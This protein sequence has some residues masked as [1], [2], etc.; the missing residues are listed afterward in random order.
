MS[1]TSRSHGDS[2]PVV[3]VDIDQTGRTPTGVPVNIEG[4]KLDFFAIHL[5]NGSSTSNPA[6]QMG[7]GGA[8][9]T[10]IKLIQQKT[11]V[12]LFQVED[13]TSSNFSV[14][15]Y[16]AEVWDRAELQSA[17]EGLGTVNGLDISG[18]WVYN[19]GFRLLAD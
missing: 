1:Y 9:E 11:T 3:H 7:A 8:I 12:Y 19:N 15:V 5:D 4:P 2:K 17:I 10:V 14:A 18:T 13:A 6:S 16:P